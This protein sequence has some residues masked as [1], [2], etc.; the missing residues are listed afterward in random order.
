MKDGNRW[1]NKKPEQ[2][3]KHVI[4][5]YF[6]RTNKKTIASEFFFVLWLANRQFSQIVRIYET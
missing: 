6:K 4:Y 3:S 5:I 1:Q 2:I